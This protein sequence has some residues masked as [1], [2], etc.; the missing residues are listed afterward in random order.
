MR[1]F[2]KPKEYFDEF[3]TEEN[4]RVEKFE[5]KINSGTLKK[6][7][8]L[9]V[10]DK[11]ILIKLGIIIA[12]YSRGDSISELKN[13]FEQIIDLFVEAWDFESYEGNLRFVSLAYL[14]DV[15][16]VIKNKIKM[17]LSQSPHYDYIIDFILYGF[18][19]DFNSKAVSFPDMHLKLLNVIESKESSLLSEYISEWYNKHD[20]C[21]WYDSH[22][23]DIN[24][25]YGYWCFES[26]AVAKRINLNCEFLKNQKYFPYDLVCFTE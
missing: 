11:L 15:D 25:Y 16:N 26:A 5:A 1:Y 23:S 4:E 14:F 13:E 7:R 19:S 20:H 22:K 3:I 8:V 6:D 17:K 21:S 10:K 18:E 2:I 24:L 12:K 9:P